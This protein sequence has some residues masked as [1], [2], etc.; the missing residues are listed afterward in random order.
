MVAHVTTV[1]S[2]VKGTFVLKT[3][4]SYHVLLPHSSQHN[5][6][7]AAKIWKS[8][9]K[10]YTKGFRTYLRPRRCFNFCKCSNLSRDNKKRSP[11]ASV[12]FLW[13]SFPRRYRDTYKKTSVFG[14]EEH[15][16]H[17]QSLENWNKMNEQWSNSSTRTAIAVLKAQQTWV[18]VGHKSTISAA[19]LRKAKIIH[20]I[21]GKMSTTVSHSVS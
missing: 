5:E 20:S 9:D 6:S 7:C 12:N 2:S 10:D 8:A 14:A 17:I 21:C 15:G 18:P 4:S 16:N 3:T 13:A 1:V 11:G 19:S